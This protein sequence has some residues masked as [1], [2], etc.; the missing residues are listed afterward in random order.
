MSKY[1]ISLVFL[2]FVGGCAAVSNQVTNFMGG[3]D[4]AKP[5]TPLKNITQSVDIKKLWDENT[6][7]GTDEQYLKLVPVYSQGKLFVADNDGDVSAIDAKTGKTIWERDTDSPITGGPGTGESLVL[8]GTGKAEVIALS[9]D[10]GEIL[11]KSKVTSEVLAAPK[12]SG[13]IIIVRTIDGKIFGLNADDGK[14]I[15][16]YDRVVPTLTLRGTSAPVIVDDLVIAGFDEGRLTAIELQTGKLVWETRIALGSGRSEL[17]RM[18]DID[19]E[20]VV[21]DGIIYVATFQGRIAAVLQDTGRILW[22]REISS[23]AGICADSRAVYVT[24]DDSNIWALDK[25]SGVSIWKQEDLAQRALTAPENFGNM[26]AVGDLE[27]YVHWLDKSNG[28]IVA[29]KQVSDEKIIAAPLSVDN[30]LYTYTSDGML[31]AYTS[32]QLDESM[33]SDEKPAEES[34]IQDEST[35]NTAGQEEIAEPAEP[36]DE[37]A[38]QTENTETKEQEEEKGFWGK[39]FSNMIHD[40]EDD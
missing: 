10:T 33:I 30:I 39:L 17:D 15:W 31:G 12:Q 22:T 5:P 36:E 16:V 13:K 20:P 32:D 18:V 4:N 24:D 25:N 1:F 35:D 2:V 8:V 26:I 28:E 40:S 37:Q 21:S 7:S 34:D 6:G 11:W 19:S 23:Y 29:R 9:I 27:G 14:R 38:S 3:E